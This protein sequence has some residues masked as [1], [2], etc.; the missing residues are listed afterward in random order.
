MLDEILESVIAL[1]LP[2]ASPYTAITSGA[3]PETNGLTMYIGPGNP[4][5]E[6]FSRG[7]DSRIVIV[8]NG[9]HSNQKT[10]LAAMANIH[11]GLS[12]R[13]SYASGAGWEIT[14]ISTSTFPNY[15][16]REASSKQWLYGSILALD[17]Y[18]RG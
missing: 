5:T 11:K 8:L 15:I 17:F 12:S 4:T 14:N 13:K 10:V 9:K 3:L 2:Y 16:E 18:M 6:Y 1:A 7:K